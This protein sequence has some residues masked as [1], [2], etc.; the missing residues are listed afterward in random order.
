MCYGMLQRPACELPVRA[1]THSEAV[2]AIFERESMQML[3]LSKEMNRIVPYHLAY[4]SFTGI[5]PGLS[6]YYGRL[7]GEHLTEAAEREWRS[8]VATA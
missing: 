4:V 8:L 2:A 7:P 1:Q 6:L 3:V 5:T